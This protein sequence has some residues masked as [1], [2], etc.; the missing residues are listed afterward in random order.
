MEICN[1]VKNDHLKNPLYK[2]HYL[3]Y[4]EDENLTIE[5]FYKNLN[6]LDDNSIEIEWLIKNIQAHFY[7]L[8]NTILN[9]LVLENLKGQDKLNYNIN[10]EMTIINLLEYFYIKKSTIIDLLDIFYMKFFPNT[11]INKKNLVEKITKEMTDYLNLNTS[12]F[13]SYRNIHKDEIIKIRDRIIHNEGYSIKAFIENNTFLFQVYDSNLDEKIF[14][15]PL[16]SYYSVRELNHK[17]PL[18]QVTDYMVVHLCN[19][20]NYI[21]LYLEFLLSKKEFDIHSI[22]ETFQTITD[23]SKYIMYKKNELS[24]LESKFI[25]LNNKFIKKI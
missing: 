20:F 2:F 8:V 22:N 1:F 21:D 16:Y 10:L 19:I 6:T 17:P 7:K 18:I 5:N 14:P 9:T 23:S 13:V 25:E 11:N 15:N 12:A 3:L 4:N 24:L